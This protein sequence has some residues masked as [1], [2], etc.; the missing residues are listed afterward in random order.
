VVNAFNLL[1]HM[2][3]ICAGT[4]AVCGLAFA[5]VALQTGQHFIAALLLAGVGTAAGFLVFNFPPA[6]VFLGDAG[7]QFLGYGLAVSTILFTFY[8]PPY[9]LFSYFVPGVVLAVPFY[10]VARVAGIRLAQRR[11][12]FEADRNHL[13]H[14]LAALGLS[15]RQAALAVYALTGASGVAAAL[16]YE[17][18]PAAGAA[19][20]A[21]VAAGLVLVGFLEA[22]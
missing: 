7:S 8:E 4:A 5:A 3:G 11:S 21:C 20:F 14:R 2:D 6:T 13:A 10:D 17:A 1:D 16:L 19:I 22:R 18:T 9:P 12:P 15:P